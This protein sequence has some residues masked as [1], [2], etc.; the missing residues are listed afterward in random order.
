MSLESKW[1]SV[2]I[3]CYNAWIY[4]SE[5]VKS[6]QEHLNW[7]LFEII[8]S[9]DW[10]NDKW[11][12]E[13]VLD[14]FDWQKWL[15][16][17]RNIENKWAQHARNLWL[18]IAQ[19]P[20]IHMLDA[21]DMLNNNF[22]NNQRSYSEKAMNI[23]QNQNIWFVHSSCIMF[24]WFNW[25]T[26]SPY[27]LREDLVVKKHHVSTFM[28]YRLEDAVKDWIYN[29][30]IKKWQ[31]WSAWI[32]LLNTRL[33]QWKTNDIWFIN[34]P[35][36][37]Y[38]EHS[39]TTR[40]SWWN[41]DEK[42]MILKTIQLYPEIFQKYFPNLNAKE[43]A[44]IVFLS[45][46]SRLLD[47]LYVASLNSID[48]AKQIIKERWW[49]IIGNSINIDKLLKIASNDLETAIRLVKEHQLELWTNINLWN[50]P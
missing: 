41:I 2:I 16:I 1:I 43:I 17:I 23:L 33:K 39:T 3:P 12:T 42:E 30:E 13:K 15:K 19:Y 35:Y 44:E 8:I 49:F 45:K 47:L 29:E 21:D 28:V 40:L 46:P 14:S 50:I 18:N 31:D 10:S 48:L 20:Y 25:Y 27:K 32:W 36:Y 6:V 34:F 26:I 5:A 37:L 38:R 22:S 24:W 9:D 4:L 7:I 11:E